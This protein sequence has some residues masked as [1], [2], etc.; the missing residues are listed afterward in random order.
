MIS[1]TLRVVYSGQRLEVS[2]SSNVFDAVLVCSGC[3]G[4][5]LDGQTAAAQVNRP[6]LATPQK[7]HTVGVTRLESMQELSE[8][9]SK[10]SLK[11][12]RNCPAVEKSVEVRVHE[13]IFAIIYPALVTTSDEGMRCGRQ[14]NY[15][16]NYMRLVA[17]CQL[18]AKIDH[19]RV[20]Q[21]D[22]KRGSDRCQHVL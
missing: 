19:E 20:G 12:V 2:H 6:G 14:L 22:R 13:A 16:S 10:K 7:H 17:Q 11:G 4:I 5:R 21:E 15:N 1:G 18:A 9:V 8:V 3:I